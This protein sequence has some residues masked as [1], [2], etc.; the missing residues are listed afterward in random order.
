MVIECEHL[1]TPRP[2]FR[3]I[4]DSVAIQSLP[5]II[6]ALIHAGFYLL[7]TFAFEDESL[8]ERMTKDAA[9]AH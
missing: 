8:P 6:Y 7:Q 5:T 3:M 1:I 2:N 4:S 9:L